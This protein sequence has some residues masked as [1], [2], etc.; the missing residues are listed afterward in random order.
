MS[1]HKHDVTIKNDFGR[2][3]WTKAHEAAFVL[4]REAAWTL[5]MTPGELMDDLEHSDR[6]CPKCKEGK[7]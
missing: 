3:R 7:H 6:E 4:L 1:K 2:V 5:Q